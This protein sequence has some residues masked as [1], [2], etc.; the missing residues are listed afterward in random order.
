M[1]GKAAYKASKQPNWVT[2]AKR[3]TFIDVPKQVNNDCGFFAVKF[4]STYDG[5][6]LVDDFGDVEVCILLVLF[7]SSFLVFLCFCRHAPAVVLVILY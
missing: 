3:P 2:I 5:D 7:S 1:Y 6:E 4:C